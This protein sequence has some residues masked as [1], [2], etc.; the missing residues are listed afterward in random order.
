MPV[1][2]LMVFPVAA[3]LIAYAVGRL[4]GQCLAAVCVGWSSVLTGWG[5]F[6]FFFIHYQPATVCAGFV[7]SSEMATSI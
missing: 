5:C 6:Q 1:L 3:F 4:V 7:S 2:A